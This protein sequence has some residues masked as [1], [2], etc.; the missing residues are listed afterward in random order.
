M[1]NS[2]PPGK[3]AVQVEHIGVDDP[4]VLKALMFQLL[5][6]TVLSSHCFQTSTCTP[7]PGGFLHRFSWI[8]DDALIGELDGKWNFLVGW[9]DKFPSPTLPGKAVQVDIRLTL[10]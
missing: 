1:L 6:S 10:G 9:N 2:A 5:E 3:A 8:K 7:R 4:P